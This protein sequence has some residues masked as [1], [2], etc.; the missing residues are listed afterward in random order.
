M[1][2]ESLTSR[3]ALSTILFIV[4][5]QVTMEVKQQAVI[6]ESTTGRNDTQKQQKNIKR[7]S[8]VSSDVLFDRRSHAVLVEAFTLRHMAAHLAQAEGAQEPRV[9]SIHQNPAPG[10]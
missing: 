3:L 5:H 6:L 7:C 1:C 4:C 2:K 9:K 8:G 10:E